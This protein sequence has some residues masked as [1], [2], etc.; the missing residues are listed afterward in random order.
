MSEREPGSRE[1]NLRRFEGGAKENARFWSRLGEKPDFA[2]TRVLEIGSG[3]GS[4]AVE[5]ALAGA[6][7][8]VGLD[9]KPEL[10]A[11]ADERV[12]ESFPELGE[13]V[14]FL[15]RD[16]KDLDEGDFDFVLAKDTFEHVLD[17]SGLLA[18]IEKR[19]RP[20][21]KVY[22]GFGP[23][24]ASPYGDHDRRRVAFAS[25]GLLGRALAALPWGHLFLERAIVRAYNRRCGTSAASLRDLGLNKL[26]Y[27][28]YARA[29][30]TSGLRVLKLAKNRGPGRLAAAFRTLAKIPFLEDFCTYNLY[31]VL[32]KP[33]AP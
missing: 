2:G 15:C 22:A 25:W 32:E 28:E 8:V 19:L 31:C 29:F 1:Y 24:Y 9:L 10:V 18:E 4:L 7:R 30:R 13:K 27:R 21:G 16:L 17:L 3:W 20:G 5:I 6:S 33:V 23:L 14:R 26:F 12:R 11:F